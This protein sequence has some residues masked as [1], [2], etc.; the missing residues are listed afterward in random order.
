MRSR[1][2]LS[3]SL[4]AVGSR[5]K[6]LNRMPEVDGCWLPWLLAVLADSMGST[7]LQVSW[8]EQRQPSFCW[9]FRVC[10]GNRGKGS[11][12]PL[13]RQKEDDEEEGE[14]VGEKPHWRLEGSG[15]GDMGPAGGIMDVPLLRLAF[16]NCQVLAPRGRSSPDQA[17]APVPWRATIPRESDRPCA[18]ASR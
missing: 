8:N 6:S 3:M 15:A 14:V 18:P 1:C 11:C 10:C 12:Q 13:V 9:T 4:A 5:S 2:K 17:A 16:Y 7:R